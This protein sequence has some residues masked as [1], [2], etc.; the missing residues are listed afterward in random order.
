MDPAAPGRQYALVR[1]VTALCIAA[2]LLGCG[3]F[4]TGQATTPPPPDPSFPVGYES[5]TSAREPVHDDANA[6]TRRLYRSP[7]GRVLVKAHHATADDTLLSVDVRRKAEGGGYGGWEYLTFDAAT[8]R[9][10]PI[11]A[12]TCDLCHAAAGPTGTYTRF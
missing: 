8:R 2:L 11:D 5:W 3:G 10:A 12:E 4:L 6:E 9:R 1:Q 7:D